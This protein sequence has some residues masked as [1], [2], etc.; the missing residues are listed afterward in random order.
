MLMLAISVL[1]VGSARAE[2]T[3]AIPYPAELKIQVEFWKKVFATHSRYQVLI[4]D[5]WHL[6]R[7]Y[8]VL[9]FR[10]LTAGVESDAYLDEYI[11]AAT[12]TE[13]ERIR[14]I[15]IKLGQGEIDE[16]G[17]TAEEKSIRGL[18]CDDKSPARFV[19]S[20]EPER[21]RAQRGLRERFA[22]GIENSRGYLPEMEAIFR[23]EGLPVELTR[24]PLIESCFNVRAYSKVGAAG[25]WQFMPGTARLYMRVDSHIDQRRDPIESTRA[26]AAL[27]RRNHEVL[28][29]WPLAVTAYNHGRAGVAHAVDDVGSSD[30]VEI[31]ARY[32]GPRF[33]FASRNFYAELL[34][35]L[36]VERDAEL[37]FGKLHPQARRRAEE[38][39]VPDP[40]SLP[41]L[42][43][44]AKTDVDTLAELNPA[45]TPDVVHGRLLV[46]KGW[47]LR[48]PVGMGSE[49]RTRYAGVKPRL[50]AKQAEQGRRNL[51]HRV[52]RGQT[53]TVI[54]K[55]YGT[56][57][58]AIERRNRLRTG[59]PLRAGKSL[60]IPRG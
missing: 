16:A 54:A 14:A 33:K 9:D 23:S 43:Q 27:L 18:F 30:I 46:P 32:R 48:V 5:T 35:A 28:G 31:I 21:I 51:T 11:D 25:V 37:H 45:L 53:L 40:V 8:S 50:Q 38:V 20:A 3:T 34:A 6:D 24:L 59:T 49:L 52:Q 56:T 1:W 13:K 47:S 55:K 44:A 58:A 36:E 22:G 29:T 26:A 57:V 15:L 19:E 39:R 2:L 10:A 41:L 17:L 12:K 4:H 42:A 60:V 7:I